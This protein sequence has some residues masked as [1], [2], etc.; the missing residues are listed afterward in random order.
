MRFGDLPFWADELSDCI[1]EAICGSERET[2]IEDCD[3]EA[4]ILPSQLLLRD[5]FFDQLIANVYQPGEVRFIYPVPVL[6]LWIIF[7]VVT[8]NPL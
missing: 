6:S 7:P 3:N 8:S 1:R 4:S 2:N 5:P